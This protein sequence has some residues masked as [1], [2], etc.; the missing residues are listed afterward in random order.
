MYKTLKWSNDTSPKKWHTKHK[1]AY[2]Y[3]LLL[4]ALELSLVDSS[5]YTNTD[6]TNKKN[7]N[8]G[9]NTQTQYKQ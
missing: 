5:P 8:K 7:I 4:T 1:H 6:K 3:L 9:N 2:T